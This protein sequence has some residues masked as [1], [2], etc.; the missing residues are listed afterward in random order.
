[1]SRFMTDIHIDSLRINFENGAGQEHR[2]RPITERAAAIFADRLI[3]YEGTRSLEI[4]RASPVSVNLAATSNEDAARMIA[5]AWLEVLA[6]K[7]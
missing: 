5:R 7:I 2:I 6:L 4:L 3:D 1:M